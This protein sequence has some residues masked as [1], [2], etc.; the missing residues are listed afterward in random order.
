MPRS[1]S[2]CCWTG[3]LRVLALKELGMSVGPCLLA[4]D[5]ETISYN[6]HINRLST[7]AEHYMS[8]APSTGA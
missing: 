8:V 5:D 7:I 6:Y 2:T 1:P 3:H 4:R